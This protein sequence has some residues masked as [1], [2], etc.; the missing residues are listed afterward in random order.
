[1]PSSFLHGSTALPFPGFQLQGRFL[2]HFYILWTLQLDVGCEALLYLKVLVF[3]FRP[4]ICPVIPILEFRL[5]L[6]GKQAI[7]SPV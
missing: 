3:H 7:H 2:F 4:E 5:M 6:S 1:M